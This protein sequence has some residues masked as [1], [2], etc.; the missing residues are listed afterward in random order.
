[1]TEQDIGRWDNRY[2]PLKKDEIILATDEVMLD[3]GSWIVTPN[4]VGTPAPDPAYTS[5]RWYRRLIQG[6]SQ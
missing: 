4:C 6:P 1:M 3:D 2:R 5:H